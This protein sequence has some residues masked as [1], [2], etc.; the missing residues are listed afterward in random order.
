M[1]I[2]DIV[3][4]DLVQEESS[5]WILREHSEFGYSDGV[6]SERYLEKVLKSA[7]DLSSGSC[8]LEGYIKDWPSE[9]HLTTKRAQLF[10]G[11]DFDPSL[12][13][14]EV[15]CGCG[16]ITR[17][18]GE[19][20]HDVVSI[21]GSIRR[22]R[23]ARLRTTGLKSVSII[24]APF[25]EIRF[26]SKFDIIFCI[27][28]YEYSASFIP[29]DD[30]YD[31]VLSY[32]SE[33]LTPNGIVVIAIE[34]QFGLKYFNS[35]REDHTG[36]LYDGLAG[37]HADRKKVKTFGKKELEDNLKRQFSK[38][39]M[40]YPYPDYKLPNCVVSDEFLSSASAGELVSQIRSRDYYGEMKKS[41]DES[42]VSIELSRNEL[43]P[44]F[45]NSFLVF[46]GKSDLAGASFSQL[47]VMV[48]SDRTGKFRTQTKI[49]YDEKRNIAV[50]K[51]PLSGEKQVVIGKLSLRESHSDWQD[52]Y[53]LQTQLYR[54]C[55]SI[56]KQ[57]GDMFAPCR[58]WL[59]FLENQSEIINGEKYVDGEYIDCNFANAYLNSGKIT[60]VDNEWIWEERIK[61]NVILIRALYTFLCRIDDTRR[62]PKVLQVR[63]YRRLIHRIAESIGANLSKDD[64]SSFIN[65]ESEFQSLVLDSDK[66]RNSRVLRWLLADRPSLLAVRRLRTIW[67]KFSLK[68]MRAVA[69]L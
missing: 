2:Q 9:Y 35:S 67:V 43:L 48:S 57:L 25:Q 69:R 56:V 34:N 49:Y 42:L 51:M 31:S 4:N 14:L 15:G 64:F 55:M 59:D 1:S 47:A 16:A 7:D 12:K 21:E 22:A 68:I 62:L 45:S 8:E 13:A 46:A 37:Y 10:A 61:V 41:W 19:T 54:N 33:M 39:E 66:R 20:F 3:E 52:S 40:Y 60:L 63:S 30:P 44:V 38:I 53:S 27:G 18:L 28:V 23:L 24:C 36:T 5:V 50:S 6:E 11:F 32:F 29:G 26:S 65:L 17:Y 58:L